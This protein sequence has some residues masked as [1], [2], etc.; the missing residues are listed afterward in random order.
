MVV[1]HLAG[2]AALEIEY[3]WGAGHQ[4]RREAHQRALVQVRMDDVGLLA[5]RDLHNLQTQQHV[6]CD[7]MPR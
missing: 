2:E 4:M 5:E 3:Q 7:L 6:E 1:D